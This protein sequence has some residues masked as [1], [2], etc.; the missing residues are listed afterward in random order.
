[1]AYNNYREEDNMNVIKQR[2]SNDCATACLLS[3]MNYYGC[4]AIYE[5]LSIQLKINNNGTNAYN[6]INIS[7]CYGFD[8]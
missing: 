7:R 5:E 1:M 4:E 6:I 3:I 2:S 8:G